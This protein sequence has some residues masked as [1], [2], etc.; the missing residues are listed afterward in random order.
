MVS[1]LAGQEAA[2][3]EHG[4]GDADVGEREELG[5]VGDAHGEQNRVARLVGCEAVICTVVR[6]AKIPTLIWKR[7][8]GW[9]KDTKKEV[10]N[11]QSGKEAASWIP[12]LNDRRRS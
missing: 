1:H 10:G 8:R 3:H 2:Q 7:G 6:R 9:E 12:M 5:E 4:Q 11:I